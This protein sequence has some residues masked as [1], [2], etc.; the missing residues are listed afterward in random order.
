M[1]PEEGPR[2]TPDSLTSSI[3]HCILLVSKYV[4]NDRPWQGHIRAHRKTTVS[5]S[6]P[7]AEVRWISS[8]QKSFA[9]WHEQG[10][11]RRTQK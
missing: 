4:P 8:L 6:G 3:A 9:E 2:T 7:F 10:L 1:W 11:P 5:A